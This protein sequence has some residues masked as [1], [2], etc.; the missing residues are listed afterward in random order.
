MAALENPGARQAVKSVSRKGVVK[1][2][3]KGSVTDQTGKLEELVGTGNLPASRLRDALTSNAPKEMDKAIKK[4][5][6]EGRVISVA[7]LTAE[8]RSEPGFLKMC[9]RVGLD[10]SWFE[11]LARERMEVYGIKEGAEE[12]IKTMESQ[13]EEEKE[14]RGA[15][16][17]DIQAVQP[18]IQKEWQ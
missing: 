8:A 2:L 12:Q 3:S 1:E 16:Q 13:Q 18:D 7:T 10:I 17:P 14:K 9:Q 11:N 15:V 6:K 5:L 4:F